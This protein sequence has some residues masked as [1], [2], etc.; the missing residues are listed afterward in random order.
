MV[1]LTLLPAI[2]VSFLLILVYEFTIDEFFLGGHGLPP[3]IDVFFCQEVS[4][5][6]FSIVSTQV[7]P[8]T[9]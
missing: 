5:P 7:N 3:L 4:D 6:L 8:Q 2:P 1:A 9:H